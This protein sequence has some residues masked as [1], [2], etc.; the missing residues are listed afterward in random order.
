VNYGTYTA[1]DCP[2]AGCPG[3]VVYN[4]NYFCEYWGWV[5]RGELPE[6]TCT[7][8]MPHPQTEYADRLLSWK[9]TGA[10][11]EGEIPDPRDRN[12]T[13]WVTHQTEPVDPNPA[14]QVSADPIK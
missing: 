2:L 12:N 13:L 11:E 4:G 10:W 9:L 7:W 6:G 3:K 1:E 14:E 5:P 8:A